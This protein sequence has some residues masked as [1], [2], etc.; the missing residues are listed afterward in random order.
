MAPPL[1]QGYRSPLMIFIGFFSLFLPETTGL[2]LPGKGPD[3]PQPGTL[4][5]KF[6]PACDL[7]KNLH[8]LYLA[9][10]LTSTDPVMSG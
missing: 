8:M 6:M 2:I 3:I 5:R 7:R 10:A 9:E 4:N 1:H